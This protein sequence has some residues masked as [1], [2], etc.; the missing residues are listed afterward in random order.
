MTQRQDLI[1]ALRASLFKHELKK[2]EQTL[3]PDPIAWFLRVLLSVLYMFLI[4]MSYSAL[5]VVG[6][7]FV[8]VLF[9]VAFF[10]P[11][12]YGLCSRWWRNNRR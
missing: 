9:L 3:N 7:I 8:S 5:G 4:V 6:P 11:H 1:D 12:I 2:A 10:M